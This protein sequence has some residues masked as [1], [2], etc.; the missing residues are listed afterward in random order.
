MAIERDVFGSYVG[1]IFVSLGFK[2]AGILLCCGLKYLGFILAGK[3][4]QYLGWWWEMVPGIGGRLGALG[5][6]E[7]IKSP[8]G[9]RGFWG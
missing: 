3:A 6:I 5:V 7:E 2:N 1:E 4:A 9:G 8:C